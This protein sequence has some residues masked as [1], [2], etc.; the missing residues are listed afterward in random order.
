MNLLELVQSMKNGTYTE[1]KVK[2]PISLSQV[3][4]GQR[5]RYHPE[6]C[7]EPVREADGWVATVVYIKSHQ[8]CEIGLRF[9]N[10][11]HS[12]H[13]LDCKTDE[14][15]GRWVSLKSIEFID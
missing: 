7:E 1:P 14:E 4:V 2:F 6:K 3:E 9:D 8:S 5:I 13:N 10:T 11:H 12:F 15:H